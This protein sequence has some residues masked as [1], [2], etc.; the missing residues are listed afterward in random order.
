MSEARVAVANLA[1]SGQL[2]PSGIGSVSASPIV[3]TSPV[4]PPPGSPVVVPSPV[5]V[6]PPGV[7]GPLTPQV[8]GSP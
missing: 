3:Q 5:V 6:V 7:I 8:R 1:A 4:V 2:P